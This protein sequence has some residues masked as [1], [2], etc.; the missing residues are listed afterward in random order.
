MAV[1]VLLPDFVNA[2][3]TRNCSV[4]K[5]Q[6]EHNILTTSRKGMGALFY[7]ILSVSPE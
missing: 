2:S 6:R 3:P 7:S 4:H 1:T 5:P